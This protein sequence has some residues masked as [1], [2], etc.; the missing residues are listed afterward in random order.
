MN[1]LSILDSQ[2]PGVQLL[3][4]IGTFKNVYELQKYR[5][6]RIESVSNSLQTIR[7]SLR[8]FKFP[9]LDGIALYCEWETDEREWAGF[10]QYR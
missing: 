7:E 10:R 4:S 5:D 2:F 9:I 6:L 3:I 8:K 1:D